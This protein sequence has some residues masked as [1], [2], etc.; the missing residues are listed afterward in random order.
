MCLRKETADRVVCTH[1]HPRPCH[2]GHHLPLCP[3]PAPAPACPQ[4]HLAQCRSVL[5]AASTAEPASDGASTPWQA[6]VPPDA[7]QTGQDLK[8]NQEGKEG[9][10]NGDERVPPSLAKGD[11]LHRAKGR[12]VNNTALTQVHNTTSN[13]PRS[14]LCLPALASSPSMGA[15]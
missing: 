12:R 1:S 3:P 11:D 6:Q 8:P 7:T 14:L 13:F 15:W 4:A 2:H 10:D 9:T 5:P